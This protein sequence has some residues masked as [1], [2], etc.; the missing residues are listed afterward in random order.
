[1]KLTCSTR[2]WTATTTALFL[3]C[4]AYPADPVG[5]ELFNGKDLQGWVPVH[6]V[7]FDVHEGNLR[8]NK[9][10]GWLRTEKEYQDFVLELEWK[11]L[12][13]K[14]DSGIFVRCGAEGK[15]WPTDG[16]QVNLRYDALGGLV[17]GYKPIV[18]A[19]SPKLPVDKWIKVR[20]EVKGKKITL[21]M[22][23]ERSWE[24]EGLDREKGYIGFQAE[25]RAFE[26]RNIR[27]QPTGAK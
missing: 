5:K 22:D 21:D 1:M 12:V 13:D 2:F 19:E 16:W 9:G 23:G 17:K 8:L 10:M 27:I 15:P 14:Y 11:A 4:A 24:Y 6:D 3:A 7:S 20:I 25:D 18:P 26:F